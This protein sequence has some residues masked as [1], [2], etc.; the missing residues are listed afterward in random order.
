MMA[1]TQ[2]IKGKEREWVNK[3]TGGAEEGQD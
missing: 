3:K 2:N 1:D